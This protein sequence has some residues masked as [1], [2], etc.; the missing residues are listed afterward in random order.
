MADSPSSRI[1]AEGT[2]APDFTLPDQNNTPVHLAGLRGKQVI[3]Y[4]YP[5]DDTPGC[6]TEACGFRDS[7]QALEARGVVVLG[8]SR[9][10]V[11]SHQRFAQK[12][13]L[14]FTLLADENGTVT[15]QYGVWGERT[16]YGKT[17]MSVLRTTFYIQP[18]G[19]IGHVWEHVKADGH[20]GAV[21]DYLRAQAA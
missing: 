1:P 19:T 5:K 17:M 16:L 18:D 15:E 14:P 2:P 9:D 8:V 7:W 10:S 20:A 3:L 13:G 12:Y 6:T 4:F 11:S 21:M